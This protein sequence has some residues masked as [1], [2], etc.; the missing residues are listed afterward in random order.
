MFNRA[1][2]IATHERNRHSKLNV[3]WKNKTLCSGLPSDQQSSS[4]SEYSHM[5]ASGEIQDIS[6]K[7]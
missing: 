2:A 7:S 5:R 4:S 6:H 1:P 3:V